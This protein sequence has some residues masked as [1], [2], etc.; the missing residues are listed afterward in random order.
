MCKCDQGKAIL[1][2]VEFRVSKIIYK[3]ICIKEHG[4][5]GW[6]LVCKSMSL[7]ILRDKTA[8]NALSSDLETRKSQN[9]PIQG[10]P[11]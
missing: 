11:W 5:W 10:W 4:L 7:S 6:G 1:D 8:E 2:G 3:D 9:F